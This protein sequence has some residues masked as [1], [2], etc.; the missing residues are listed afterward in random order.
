MRHQ[1]LVK[2]LAAALLTATAGMALAQQ[3]VVQPTQGQSAAQMEKDKAD[4]YT[5]AKQSTGYDPALAAQTS[6]TATTTPPSGG[7]MRGAAVGAAAGA[8]GAQVRSNQYENVPS[9]VEEEYRQNQAKSAAAAG[10]VVGGARQRQ[11]RRQ[12]SAQ[13]QQAAAQ[14]SSNASAFNQ[15]YN[16]CLAGRGY[17]VTQ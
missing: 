10:A 7:R 8:V 14:E 13:Q 2:A 5:I 17:Q 16:A 11:Q 1:T 15:A 4:C 12:Q 3:G 6:S 9:K